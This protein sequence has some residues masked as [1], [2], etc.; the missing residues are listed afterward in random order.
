MLLPLLLQTDASAVGLVAILEQDSRVIA[1]ASCT[2]KQCQTAIQHNR[3]IMSGSSLCV[4][5]VLPLLT[6]PLLSI[7]DRSCSLAVS[8]GSKSKM[9]GLLCCWA[10][11]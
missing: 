11:E 5:A 4:K 10:G 3:A 9:E 7:T 1:Y 6:W 8:F 2:L